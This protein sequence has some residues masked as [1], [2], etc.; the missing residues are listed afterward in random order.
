[1]VNYQWKCIAIYESKTYDMFESI[2]AVIRP[3]CCSMRSGVYTVWGSL[4]WHINLS[5]NVA[6]PSV[7]P[8]APT[9]PRPPSW[10]VYWFPLASYVV[11][12]YL[13]T[14]FL[15]H[16]PLKSNVSYLRYTRVTKKSKQNYFCYY[17]AVKLPPNL[18]F[19]G[20]KMAN[21]LK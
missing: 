6:P 3:F 13:N 11:S 4:A 2:N 5:G 1:M 18:T 7:S 8:L 14:P 9:L 19:F 20:I 21:S 15:R 17:Y 12:F 16:S 10:P